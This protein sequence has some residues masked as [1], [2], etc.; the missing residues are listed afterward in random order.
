M[1]NIAVLISGSGSN[2]QAI[3]DKKN[4]GDMKNVNIACVISNK[5]SAYGLIRA[6]ENNIPAFAILKK[7]YENFDLWQKAL[8]KKLREYKID[9]VVL[10]GFLTILTDEFINEFDKKII[11]VHPS[12]IPSFCGEGYYGL[13]VHTAALKKGVKVSGA[14]VHYVDSGVDTGEIILQK[15]VEVLKTDDAHSLQQRIMQE[16]EWHILPMAIKQIADE[17]ENNK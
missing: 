13:A 14:T 10:A 6:K 11:N 12:L 7:D 15:A 3:I 4:I 5:S 8:I 2:L 9:L 17:K 1:L 16:A